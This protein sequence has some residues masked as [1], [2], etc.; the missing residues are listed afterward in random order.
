MNNSKLLLIEQAQ[1]SKYWGLIEIDLW[2][3]IYM[4]NQ[5]F[6]AKKVISTEGSLFWNDSRL[7]M[8]IPKTII[9]LID[10]LDD[11]SDNKCFRISFCRDFEALEDEIQKFKEINVVPLLL[12]FSKKGT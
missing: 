5:I 2:R 11:K 3:I 12:S 10:G 8:T 9:E 4:N 1:S 6:P 7:R